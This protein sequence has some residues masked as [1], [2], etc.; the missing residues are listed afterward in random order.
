VHLPAFCAKPLCTAP[1]SADH[2]TEHNAFLNLPFVFYSVACSNNQPGAPFLDRQAIAQFFLFQFEA[3]I[4]LFFFLNLSS[5]LPRQ[6]LLHCPRL[7]SP[8]SSFLVS[9]CP[10]QT[11][12]CFLLAYVLALKKI[13]PLHIQKPTHTFCFYNKEMPCT[14]WYGYN[15]LHYLYLPYNTIQCICLFHPI[16]PYCTWRLLFSW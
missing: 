9:P 7:S 13:P 16:F 14:I 2:N 8:L 4:F 5:H 1:M 15:T 6:S 12:L 11:I 10:K 3:I